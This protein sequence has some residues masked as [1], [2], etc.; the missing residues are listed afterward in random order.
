MLTLSWQYRT[1][2]LNNLSLALKIIL[3][4]KSFHRNQFHKHAE[5]VFNFFLKYEF[6]LPKLF[7]LGMKL[8]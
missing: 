5:I 7:Q 2:L 1:L 8:E 4:G 3:F 6:I